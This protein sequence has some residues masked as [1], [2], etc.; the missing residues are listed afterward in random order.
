MARDLSYDAAFFRYVN[1]TATSA[2]SAVVPPLLDAL[3]P[4]S[5]LDVGCGQGAWLSVWGKSGVGDLRGIDGDYVERSRLLIPEGSFEAR[6]LSLPFDL[7]RRFD[8]VECL[9]VA[10]HLPPAS[11]DGLIDSLTR[12]GDLVL[13]SAAPPG[14]GG[15]EHV[16]ERSYDFW[17]AEFLKR[18]YVALDFVRPLI[19]R[20]PSVSDWY[21]YNTLLYARRSVLARLPDRVRASELPVGQPVPDVAPLAYR[22]RRQF[23]RLLPPP[24]MTALARIKER[25]RRSTPARS[26]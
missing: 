3:K 22:V 2:A 23:V 16:N 20:D 7:G 18:D 5:V 8:L 11:N 21:R 14:Q 17:R 13:F 25:L 19:A 6:D 26:A 1:A 10:E 15:H 4:A 12:H 24:V 9:E